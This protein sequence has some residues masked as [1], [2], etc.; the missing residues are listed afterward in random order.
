MS[1]IAVPGA[2]VRVESRPFL[3]WLEV[4]LLATMF[5]AADACKPLHI[6]DTAYYY[7]ARQMAEHPADPYDFRIL[8]YET[9]EPANDVL[10]PPVL[11]Y[12]W[13]LAVR[14]FGQQPVLW[15]LWLFPFAL[16]FVATCKMLFARF[17]PGLQRPLLWMTVF[18]P[19]FLSAFNLMLDIPSLALG[20]AGVV[21]FMKAIERGSVS[22]ALAAGLI[23]GLAMQTKYT[24]LLLPG[25]FAAYALTVRRPVISRLI[26]WLV[27]CAGSL[28][29]FAGWEAFLT[30]RH[31]EMGSHFLNSV[32][33]NQNPMLPLL[34][35]NAQALLPLIGSVLAPIGLLAAAALRW[36]LRF[37]GIMAGLIVLVGALIASLDIRFTNDGLAR[38]GSQVE[39]DGSYPFEP[40]LL[41]A[42]G[43]ATAAA[44]LLV[45]WRLVRGTSDNEQRRLDWFLVLWLLVELAGY[46]ILNPFPAVRRLMGVTVVATLLA[47][48]LASRASPGKRHVLVWAIAA[49]NMVLGLAY[50]AV[51]YHEAWGRK[52]AT[53][54]AAAF[55]KRRDTEHAVWFTG[56][57]GLQFYAEQAGMSPV[58]LGETRLSAGDW[59]VVPDIGV[60]AQD[61]RPDGAR[62]TAVESISVTSPAP[63][64]TVGQ[65]YGG[66]YGTGTGAALVHQNGPIV[67]VTIYR[68][69]RAF[70]VQ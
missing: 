67:R 26:L 48:R 19:V 38:G 63:V 47:G 5:T 34:W 23:G 4:L 55:I 33:Q 53:E 21:L 51:D 2:Q 46:M 58:A 31:P 10:A 44:I 49:F 39:P 20:L 62:M 25:V 42:L 59:V 70:L 66:Y 50:A 7:Y 45:S 22:W 64:T 52:T 16:L 37:V 27:C 40:V 13:A 15:K 9:W 30:W 43:L 35:Q 1:E 60:T 54:A 24:A 12:W 3:G 56:H 14:L 29:V 18:S 61:F 69:K 65:A 32:R 11:P 28:A 8:W 41:G 57:W 6:D 68:V 17:A 36:P